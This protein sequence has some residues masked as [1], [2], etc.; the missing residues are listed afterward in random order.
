MSCTWRRGAAHRRQ[1]IHTLSHTLAYTS[2]SHRSESPQATL[3]KKKLLA[4]ENAVCGRGEQPRAPMRDLARKVSGWCKE[5]SINACSAVGKC[6]ASRCALVRAHTHENTRRLTRKVIRPCDA[7]SEATSVRRAT[8][9]LKWVTRAYIDAT[10]SGACARSTL[11]TFVSTC[12]TRGAKQQSHEI[13]NERQSYHSSAV[14]P[15]Q[16]KSTHR[17]GLSTKTAC[18][19]EGRLHLV[20]DLARK[21]GEQVFVHNACQTT[22]RPSLPGVK[23][24]RLHRNMRP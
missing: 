7:R 9:H 19:S 8:Q 3:D 4:S 15:N 16:R 12:G 22:L 17:D 11:R 1:H 6:Y 13:R 14:R 2:E 21:C 20:T 10:A 18:A 5:C 24:V 23:S